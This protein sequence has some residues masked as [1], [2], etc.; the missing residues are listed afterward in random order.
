M[1]RPVSWLPR[2]PEIRKSVDGSV[3]SHYTR[4][5]LQRLFQLQPRA[6]GKLIALLPTTP[7]GSSHLVSKNDLAGFLERVRRA[8][9]VPALLDAMR[10][11]AARPSHKKLRH[12]VRTDVAAPSLEGMPLAIQLAPGELRVTFDTTESLAESMYQIALLLR[13]QGDEFARLY[14]PVA[15]KQEEMEARDDLRRMFD[16]LR[17]MEAARE[18][19]AAA[20]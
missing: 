7:V 13:D 1:S 6:A 9:D 14:E 8:D 19:I 3:R 11:E 10:K 15:V 5:D 20:V 12:M 4:P 18:K 16:R 2:L 17:A